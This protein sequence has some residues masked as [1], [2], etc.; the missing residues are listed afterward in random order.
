VHTLPRASDL[1]GQVSQRFDDLW[2]R[3]PRKEQRDRAARDWISLV[4]VENEAAAMA[5]AE[6]YL[7]SKEVSEGIVKNP[8]NFLEQQHRD[9]WGG[10][11]PKSR[12]SM[13]DLA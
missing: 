13:W 5:C 1:N 6:R 10:D 4:T 2:Q 9:S 8:H 3:W 12:R 7:A 11:W